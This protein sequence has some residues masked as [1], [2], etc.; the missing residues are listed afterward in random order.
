M[1][2]LTLPTIS[3][4]ED[5]V[6]ALRVW[7]AA[8]TRTTKQLKTPRIPWNFQAQGKVGGIQLNWARTLDATGYEVVWSETG[9]LSDPIVISL[10]SPNQVSYFHTVGSS[11]VT[12]YYKVR[13]Y[14]AG[15]QGRVVYG[16]YSGVVSSTSQPAPTFIAPVVRDTTT[17]DAAQVGKG[18][19]IR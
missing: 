16:P 19:F 5:V 17:T 15:D 2:R 11:G 6:P 12:L 4:T 14:N 7:Q 9:D 13:A 10:D 18:I 8:L 3:R 1:A